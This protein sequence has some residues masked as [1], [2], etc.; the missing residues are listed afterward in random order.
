M[1]GTDWLEVGI[2]IVLIAVVA[3]SAATE[4]AITRTNRVR[5]VRLLEEHRRGAG[6]LSRSAARRSPRRSR[7]GTPR[8]PARS[9]PP[10]S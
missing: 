4:V 2:I 10:P 9:S 7:S 5:A 1:N 8:E 6:A 3:F